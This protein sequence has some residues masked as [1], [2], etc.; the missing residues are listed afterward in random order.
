MK[1]LA[2]ALLLLGVIRHYGY[3]LVSPENQALLWNATGAAV[4]L[5]GLIFLWVR[6]AG[7]WP[8]L[9]WWAVEEL[10]VIA[11]SVGRILAP[12]DV[13]P[14][15]DQCSALIGFDLGSLGILCIALILWAL[16]VNLTGLQNKGKKP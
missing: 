4:I 9:L 5:M 2:V 14:G 12:W 1:P 8:V 3:E 7:M 11:C 10:Q 15:Q 16:P 6:Y 13:K